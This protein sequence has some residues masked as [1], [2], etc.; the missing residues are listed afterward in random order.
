M[1]AMNFINILTYHIEQNKFI[2]ELK[3]NN[4]ILD[5]KCINKRKSNTHKNVNINKHTHTRTCKKSNEHLDHF[6][7]VYQFILNDINIHLN[8]KIDTLILMYEIKHNCEILP[9]YELVKLFYDATIHLN[10]KHFK[11]MILSDTEANFL[12]SLYSILD[13]TT[14]D[15][16]IIQVILRDTNNK[17]EKHFLENIKETIIKN[18]KKHNTFILEI[19]RNSI[20]ESIQFKI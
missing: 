6:I 14:I 13:N 8:S 5:T 19:L 2:E 18:E 20:N 17:Y 3:N 10:I 12:H 9:I 16:I 7:N 1:N 11:I 15:N 4:I